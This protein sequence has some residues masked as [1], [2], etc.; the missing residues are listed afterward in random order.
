MKWDGWLSWDPALDLNS[1]ASPLINLRGQGVNSRQAAGVE[2]AF[3][4]GR[5]AAIRPVAAGL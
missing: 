1:P 5:H 4:F 3:L 2:S